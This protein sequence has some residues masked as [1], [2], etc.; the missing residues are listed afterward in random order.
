MSVAASEILSQ[1]RTKGA[2]VWLDNGEL[3]YRAPKGALAPGEIERLRA[4]KVELV[5]LLEHGTRHAARRTARARRY[6]A[7]V[8]FSQLAHWNIHELRYEPSVRNVAHAMRLCG[9]LDIEVFRRSVGELVQRHDALRTQIMICDGVPVQEVSDDNHFRLRVDYHMGLPAVIRENEVE[10]ALARLMLEPV[11]VSSDALFDAALL[12]FR[13]DEHVFVV[14]MEH[15]ISDG[16]SLKVLWRDLAALY[17]RAVRTGRCYL[18][19]YPFQFPDYAVWQQNSHEAWLARHGNYWEKRL[20]GCERLQFPQGGI[21]RGESGWGAVPLHL[22][23]HL[24]GALREWSHTERTTLVMSVFTAYVALVAR[25][26]NS[27]DALIQYQIDGRASPGVEN[28]IGYFASKLAL[29]VQ[30]NGEET[31]RELLGRVLE[32]YCTAY[33][34]ADSSYIASREPRLQLTKSPTFNWLPQASLRNDLSGTRDEHGLPECIPMSF[35]PPTMNHLNIDGEPLTI[36]S[37]SDGSISGILYYPRR[38]FSSVTMER[39][40]RNLSLFIRAMVQRP[41]GRLREI[42]LCD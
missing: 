30:L 3:R 27:S 17:G 4:H 11:D 1:L 8:S 35:V 20:E 15:M 32:E 39:F 26:C 36:L 41:H 6:R 9:P 2:R 31:F 33:E 38:R 42:V 22:D 29:R 16:Y 14:A 21:F 28:A 10:R 34:H 37:E 5:R 24:T 19:D 12:R 40:G 7:P 18:D 13:D 25:W 23:G